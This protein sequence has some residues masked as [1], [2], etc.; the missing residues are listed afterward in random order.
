MTQRCMQRFQSGTIRENFIVIRFE[1]R[2]YSLEKTLFYSFKF[3][4]IFFH[5]DVFQ[6]PL[7][8]EKNKCASRTFDD[9]NGQRMVILFISIY[10]E[11]RKKSYSASILLSCDEL[12][13]TVHI[14]T[15]TLEHSSNAMP[16]FYEWLRDTHTHFFWIQE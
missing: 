8:E 10:W 12:F 13:N 11:C 7:R 15:L 3:T 9:R 2:N 6:C 4:I 14:Y 16:I 5:A 1:N